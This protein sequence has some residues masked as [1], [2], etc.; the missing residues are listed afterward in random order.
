MTIRFIEKNGERILEV[1]ASGKL[2]HQDYR[3]FAPQFDRIVERHG[4]VRILFE[5]E[6]FRG[7]G[8]ATLW[9]DVR[10][11]WKYFR[12][13]ERLAIVGDKRWQ[14]W[15][16][17]ACRPFTTAEIRYFERARMGE[18][19]NWLEETSGSDGAVKKPIL[20]VFQSRDQTKAYYNKISRFYDLLSDR[21]EAPMRKAGLDLLKACPGERVLE[22]G[23]G[24]GHTLAALAKAVGP[25]GKV[26]GIDLSDQMVRLAKKNLAKAGLLDCARLRQGDAAHL[27]F[28]ADTMDAVFMSF[29]LELFDTPEI[30]QVLNECRRV[31][32]PRG[33]IVVV[34]MSKEGAREP[35]AGVYE[36]TH[37]HFPNFVDCRPIYIRESLEAAGFKIRK[38]QRKRMWIS[39]E[40]VLG[41]R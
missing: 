21:S 13:I 32:K 34:G 39:V 40:I 15:M 1:V 35:L 11:D 30:P 10:I 5:M 7:W 3:R 17:E 37:R 4:K 26:F 2:T 24:T 25:E 27:P 18:A 33:R 28:S 12:A 29:T 14:K 6:N 23:F 41:V 20:R 38:A 16:S 8:A 19:R 9:D 31:L 22:I 36:W